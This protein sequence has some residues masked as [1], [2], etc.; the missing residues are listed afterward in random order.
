MGMRCFV[1]TGNE[2]IYNLWC[3]GS[4]KPNL[5]ATLIQIVYETR[6]TGSN[7]Y[8]YVLVDGWDFI[9]RVDVQDIRFNNGGL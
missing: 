6:A 8:A 5:N 3:N 7:A 2:R 4:D 1:A 9:K